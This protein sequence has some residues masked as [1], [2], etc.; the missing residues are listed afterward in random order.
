MKRQETL[1]RAFVALMI[2]GGNDLKT[3]VLMRY[4]LTIIAVALFAPVV[5]SQ[6]DGSTF[7]PISLPS[8]FPE[9]KRF[10]R[11]PKPDPYL[12]EKIAKAGWLRKAHLL[13]ERS[14]HFKE[15]GMGE[16]S[17]RDANTAVSLA[18]YDVK[19]FTTG[20]DL[21]LQDRT[22][23]AAE[24]VIALADAFIAEHPTSVAAY[25]LRSVARSIKK[26]YVKAIADITHAIDAEPINL[27]YL[28][29][30]SSML[31]SIARETGS[32]GLFQLAIERLENNLSAETHPVRRIWKKHPVASAYLARSEYFKRIGDRVTQIADLTKAIEVSSDP[33]FYLEMRA[34]AYKGSVRYVDAISDLTKAL[35][36]LDK[37]SR[38]SRG[39]LDEA[40][41]RVNRGDNYVLLESFDKALEDYEI[42]LKLDP[43]AKKYIESKIIAAKQ[44]RENKLRQ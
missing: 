23:Q 40:R 15:A 2:A 22:E 38:Y 27:N 24:R 35:D 13:L 17:W 11:A 43:R 12:N 5:L 1:I 26:D 31:H 20:A 19:V 16:S 25:H 29:H 32:L 37:Q 6:T 3:S 39:H 36:G 9:N 42:A 34:L 44:N 10:S 4:F 7:Q 8:N 18:P 14:R 21:M 33:R 28:N 41:I 30:L